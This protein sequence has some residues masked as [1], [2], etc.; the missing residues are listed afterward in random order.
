MVSKIQEETQHL[1]RNPQGEGTLEEAIHF[2]TSQ[3]EGFHA[4]F[5]FSPECTV[6][7][8]ESRVFYTDSNIKVERID[9]KRRERAQNGASKKWNLG[10][11]LVFVNA[12]GE[13]LEVFLILRHDGKHPNGHIARLPSETFAKY[14]RGKRPI[15]FL[16]TESGCL[17]A[18]PFETIVN[19]FTSN[20]S[21]L[22]RGRSCLILTDNLAIHYQPKLITKLA[23]HGF[24][25]CGIY[26]YN[27]NRIL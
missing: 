26:P 16:F 9:A 19:E 15:K 21:Q 5:H 11:L 27:P 7:L 6:N 8:D 17:T 2:S 14:T 18:L 1:S 12:I 23:K 25:T 10:T 20:W 24:A 4:C 13:V 22:N 3:Y